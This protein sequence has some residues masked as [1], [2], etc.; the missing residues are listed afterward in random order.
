MAIW[1]LLGLVVGLILRRT[2]PGRAMYAHGLEPA[3]RGPRA[4]ADALGLG[5]RLRRQRPRR[6]ADRHAAGGLR[7]LGHQNVGD[8]YLFE[9]LA[10]VF[11][12]GTS[13]LGARGDY[14]RT[15]LGALILIQTDDPGRPG[16]TTADQQIIFGVLVLLVV[17]IYGRDRRLRDR[18]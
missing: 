7:G 13:I 10:A 16:Y 11:V 4:R 9:S 18:V 3:R 8:P 2:R 6:G 12:G 17:G 1:L 15:V 14:W 5:R